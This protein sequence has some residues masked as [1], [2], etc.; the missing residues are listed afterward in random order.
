MKYEILL[1]KVGSDNI[2]HFKRL[3]KQVLLVTQFMK[4]KLLVTQVKDIDN[5]LDL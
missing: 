5:F 3:L 4:F 1:R 2:Q